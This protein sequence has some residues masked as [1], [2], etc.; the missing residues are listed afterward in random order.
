MKKSSLLS[1]SLLI[2]SLIF[3][4]CVSLEINPVSG[5][6]RAFGYSWE[7]E[8]KIGAE[9]DQEII[10]QYGLYQDEELSD[11]VSALGQDLLEVSH[12]RREDTPAEF[13]N[14]AFTFRVLDSPVVNAF[15]LPGGYIYV[16]R[17]LLSHLN[18]EAQLAVV[19]GHEIG[20]VAARHASQRAAEQQF[21]QLAIM[22]G[23]LIGESLGYD[24]SSLYQLSSQTAQLM[25]LKYSRDDE[26][27]SDALGV[28]Y[29]SMKSYQAAEGAEFFRSL[30]RISQQHSGGVPTLLSSH[31][32]P[33]EREKTIPRLAQE[34]E[35][36]G[37]EQS[38]VD[39]EEYL[40]KIE[41][42]I[43]DQNP[44]QGFTRNGTFY[45]PDLKFQFPVPSG[46]QVVNQPAAVI[47]INDAQNAVTQFT[48]DSRNDTPQS[49]VQ[50]FLSQKGIQTISQ[51]NYSVQGLNGY[52]ALASATTQ[53][54][55]QVKLKVTALLYEGTVY[56]FLSYT[57]SSQ[58]DQYKGQFEISP[59]GFRKLTDSAILNI[60]PAR[61][62][63]V[64]A[65]Y[66]GA[67]SSFLPN[68][69]PLDIKA[70]DVAIIN[71]VN[72]NDTIEKGSILKIPVQ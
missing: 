54:S 45:H 68:P 24:A 36:K 42:L 46:F 5:N 11:Y 60:R 49:S 28:E 48:L 6:K 61:L 39:K 4:G 59:D 18:N 1:V 50:S 43:F 7:Q 53:D 29:S 30:E 38:I 17:G 57:S 58:Y 35:Q 12:M 64:V 25:F 67:F 19:L 47:M 41:N 71:Q 52:E 51:S 63:L 27:E 31:P 66:R 16:T 65:D 10:Q 37:Y 62:Q 9:A 69:L 33:G 26:R 22:S 13:K 3:Q 32:D 55:S 14:T 23:A 40:S 56:R 21:G 8:K 44:R 2:I 70:E 20:H 72:L 34:W 15:A